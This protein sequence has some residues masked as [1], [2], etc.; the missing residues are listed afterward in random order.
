MVLS[1]KQKWGIGIG[2]GLLSIGAL[3]VRRLIKRIQN[4]GVSLNNV[5]VKT[6]NKEKLNFDVI[7][8]YKNNSELTIN[9][10]SQKYDVY[11]NDVYVTTMTN[12]NENVLKAKAISPLQFSVNLNLPEIDSKIRTSYAKMILEPKNVPVKFVMKFKARVGFLRLPY[13]YILNT[14]LKEILSWYIPIFK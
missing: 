9:L 4:F 6:F 1:K 2:L 12:D 3:Y 13:T 5:K 14:N 8:N 10:V 7:L 11:I